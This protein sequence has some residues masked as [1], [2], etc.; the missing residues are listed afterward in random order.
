MKLLHVLLV[1][2]LSTAAAAQFAPSYLRLNDD[3]AP[4]APEPRMA[5]NVIIDI[6]PSQD[7]DIF[8]LG[9]GSGVTR[10]TADPAE[11]RG[12]RFE[13]YG[14]AQGLGKG[15]ISGLLVT[16]TII[17]ASFAFDTSVGISG[18]GGGLSYS[19]DGGLTWTH[20]PQPR[21]RIYN[22]DPSNGYDRIL[23]YWPTT[24]NVDNITYDIAMSDRYVWIV[25]KGG[26]LRRH[27]ICEEDSCYCDYNDTTGWKVVSPDEFPFHPGERLNHRAFS[28]LYADSA[29]YVGTAGGINKST[30][31]GATWRNIN[32]L[33][34]D[35]SGNFV[36]ALA[37]Q[38]SEHAV[39]AATWRAEGTDEYYAVSRSTDKGATWT[40][41]LDSAQVT[42][43]LGRFETVRA[44]G[45]GFDGRTVYVCDDLGLWKSPDGGTT[46]DL[47][48]TIEDASTGHRM[49]ENEIYSAFKDLNDRLWIGGVDGLA[50]SRDNGVT[51]ELFQTALPLVH[52]GRGTDTYAYPNPWS[53][54]RFGPVKLRYSTTGGAVK[55][56]IYDFAMSKV[57][58][59]PA[60]SRPAGEQY[61]VWDG[62]KDGVIVANGTYFYK[63]EKPGG[64][65]WGK[66]I[67]LD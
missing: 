7:P 46:W 64:D 2:V 57:V 42:R 19:R 25:S 26:G 5:S 20:V 23:G 8:W 34:S 17:W 13:S 53:P 24:T 40:A 35:I 31:N 41:H 22:L 67:V 58:E 48:A 62:R 66:L 61:E 29:L 11:P 18:A 1:F 39:W 9:T 6:M 54:Q 47:F 15:G 3:P 44:H 36:T 45:F 12:F 4:P 50:L 30:D 16:N 51:W 37:Y 55:I 21:D 43:A 63:I 59:L 38:P 32:A 33:N 49:Y 27:A 65:V 10:V 60:L 52:P 56:S 14:A 28:V